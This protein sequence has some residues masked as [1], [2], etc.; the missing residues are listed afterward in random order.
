MESP[1]AVGEKLSRGATPDVEANQLAQERLEATT[2]ERM[3]KLPNCTKNFF[4]PI[5]AVSSIVL[6]CQT[7]LFIS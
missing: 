5:I 1:I 4:N 7:I 3:R 6:R 2:P